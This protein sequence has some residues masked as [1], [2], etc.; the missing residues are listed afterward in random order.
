MGAEY[1]ERADVFSYG[2][3]LACGLIARAHDADADKFRSVDYSLDETKFRK[4]CVIP[5]SLARFLPISL[6]KLGC[7][8]FL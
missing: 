7:T 2:L 3:V 8:P 4:T 1:N 6:P 5:R